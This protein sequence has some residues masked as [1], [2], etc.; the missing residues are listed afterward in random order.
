QPP[1]LTKSAKQALIVTHLRQTGTCH[2]L[3]ELEKTLPGV[4]S[5]HGLQVKEYLQELADEGRVRVEKIGSGNWYWCFGADEVRER[6][7]RVR[8]LLGEVERLERGIGE[9]EG[10]VE[11]YEKGGEGGGGGLEEERQRLVERRDGLER[12]VKGLQAQLRGLETGTGMG[13]GP[14]G[15]SV[16][17]LRGEIEEAKQ[18]A[19][20]WTDN[21]YVLEGYVGRLSGGDREVLRAVQ[22]ECYG[23]E[24][25][26]EEGGLREIF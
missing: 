6:E 19:Q 15:K 22:R 8:G 13:M 14:Q 5:I 10:R 23:E 18:R 2:T 20:M 7:E 26:E 9:M 25:V 16:S 24:F 4:A 21:I 17:R 1:K 3:K 11:E 12:E